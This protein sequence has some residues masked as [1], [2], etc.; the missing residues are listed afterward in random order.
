[1]PK[2]SRRERAAKSFRKPVRRDAKTPPKPRWQRVSTWAATAI[3]APVLVAIL[4]AAITQGLHFSNSHSPATRIN[5]DMSRPP[6]KIDR[7]EIVP[8]TDNFVA[9]ERFSPRQVRKGLGGFPSSVGAVSTL[10]A[11]IQ[12]SAEGNRAG[13]VRIVNIHVLK[14]CRSPLTGTL[15]LSP[16]PQGTVPAVDLGFNLD[17]TDP[18]PQ[19]TLRRQ[20][21]DGS[22]RLGADYFLQHE[23]DLKLGEP[24]TLV[25]GAQTYHYDCKFRFKLDLVVNG[26]ATTELID[27]H[28]KPFQV[29]AQ[30]E[31]RSP[32]ANIDFRAYSAL[33]VLSNMAHPSS[34]GPLRWVEENPRRWREPSIFK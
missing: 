7:I 24:L 15:F 11:D 31:P 33:Y 34:T 23:Y 10:G 20:N 12:V 8:Y 30:I 16:P 2:R 6:V 5:A 17:K 25:L 3:F 9:A 32:S 13:L 22:L 1:M 28:G 4:I 26:V 27:N 29:C 21:I 14:T 19:E 18:R